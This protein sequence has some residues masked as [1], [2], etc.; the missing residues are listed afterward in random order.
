MTSLD[1][2]CRILRLRLRLRFRR[3]FPIRR[4]L[5]GVLRQ[6]KVS[7]SPASSSVSPSGEMPVQLKSSSGSKFSVS[8]LVLVTTI[9][10][11]TV[12][13]TSAVSS[14]VVKDWSA[15]AILWNFSIVNCDD[16]SMDFG[17]AASAEPDEDAEDRHRGEE[18]RDHARP[19][20]PGH[21]G[22]SSL[23]SRSRAPCPTRSIHGQLSSLDAID[24]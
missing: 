6:V 9:S 1:S 13:P 14:S 4:I 3:R 19:P 12:W 20:A 22:T 11:S 18:Q 8:S 24:W 16:S 21:C 23:D 17:R 7:L 10:Y 15:P 5:R 2:G